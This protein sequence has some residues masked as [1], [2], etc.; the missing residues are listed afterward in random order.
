MHKDVLLPGPRNSI[1]D[2]PGLLIGNAEDR[3]VRSGVTVILAEEPCLAVVDLRGGAPGTRE[4]DLLRPEC[5]VE[6]I[7]A[8]VFSGGSAHGLEAAGGV[9]AALA[10]SGRGFPAG[11]FRV[12]IVPAAILFDLAN[13]GHKDW[14]DQPPYRQLGIDALKAAAKD[15]C[16]GNAGAGFGAIAGSLKGG[17]G[18]A[19]LTEGNGITIGAIAAVNSLGETVMSEDGSFW[20]WPFEQQGEFGGMAPP[21]RRPAFGGPISRLRPGTNTTLVAVGTDARL[22]AASAKRLAIMAQDG[23]AA[24]VR[25]AHSPYDGDILFLLSTGRKV[26]AD[27]AADLVRLGMMASATVARAIA[28]GVYHAESLGEQKSW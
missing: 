19:S 17:L 2:V 28:R 22:D 20:A 13:G 25:P 12:P 8:L 9:T 3:K 15:F 18:S 4:T 23:I 11:N 16:V 5:L 26:L 10:E 7:D 21:S 6:K 1:A 27:P 14:G 24:A